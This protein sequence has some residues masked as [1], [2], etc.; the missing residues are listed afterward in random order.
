VVC[1]VEHRSR[2]SIAG[3][4]GEVSRKCRRWSWGNHRQGGLGCWELEVAEL[5]NAGEGQVAQLGEV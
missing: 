5:G 2:G 4:D 1:W 3:D